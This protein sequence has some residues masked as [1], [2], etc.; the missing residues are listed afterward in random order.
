MNHLLWDSC[1]KYSL[2]QTCNEQ[3]ESLPIDISMFTVPWTSPA[4]ARYLLATDLRKTE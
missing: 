2:L 1:N 3:S 4:S